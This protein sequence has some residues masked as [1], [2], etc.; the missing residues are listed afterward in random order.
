MKIDLVIGKVAYGKV[1]GT[2]QVSFMYTGKA[3][4]KRHCSGGHL[5]VLCGTIAEDMN[6]L[7]GLPIEVVFD[8]TKHLKRT[9][10]IL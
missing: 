1:R 7:C 6:A 5:A 4:N 2:R 3:I 9:V 8:G 10:N